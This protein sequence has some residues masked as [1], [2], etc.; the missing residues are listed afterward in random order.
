[1]NEDNDLNESL[2][3]ESARKEPIN[4][5]DLAG[6]NGNRQADKEGIGEA[7]IDA[8]ETS[9]KVAKD[10]KDKKKSIDDEQN[11]KI[12]ELVNDL[13]RTR[14]D[15]E[16]FRRQTDVQKEQFGNAVKFATVKKLLPILDDIDRAISANPDTLGPLAK[17]L[18]KSIK[19]LGLSRIPAEI[20]SAFNLDIHDAV[21]VEGD[22][23]EE[24][25][26]EVLRPGYYFDGVVI[27]PTMVKVKK[28]WKFPL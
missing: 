25:I 5:N 24:V 26:G 11:A 1:M 12:K 18:E 23:D 27:R 7:V 15:F 16:N 10:K 2:M 4:P 9:A 13:Q 21:M 19:E 14:A 17:N 8:A 20:G 28:Q 6:S 22:G 3:S